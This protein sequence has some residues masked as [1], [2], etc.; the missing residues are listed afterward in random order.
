MLETVER[1]FKELAPAVDF[2][3]LRFVSEQ[4]EAIEVRQDVLQP[5]DTDDDVGVMITVV[6]GGGLGYSATS[7]L[8]LSGLHAALERATDWARKTAGHA[9]VDHGRIARPAPVGDYSASVA[10]PWEDTPLG[11]R[12]DRV[13]T[14]CQRLKTDDRIVDWSASLWWLASEQLYLTSDGGRTH[15]KFEYLIPGLS[16]TANEGSETVNRRYG[17][18]DFGRQGGLEILD[19]VDFDHQAPR[20]ADEVIQL[21]LAPNCPTG[22]MDLL[23]APDQMYLQIHESI[24]H[25][26]ELDRILGDERNYAGTSF[27]TLDMLGS[28]RYGSDLLNITFDPT[29]ADEFATYQWDDDG[30]AAD[31]QYIIRD[32]ILERALGGIT[33]QLRADQPGVANSRA[34]SWNR[35]P[36]DR[37]AN[38]NLEPG[39]ST[40]DELIGGVEN[41]IY[42]QRNTSWSIDDSRNKFQFGC[43]MGHLIRD[44]ELA[45]MV[46]KPNYKGISA[47]FWRALKGVGDADHFEVLGT[48]F[49]GK[50]E[51]NQVIR[52]GHASPPALFGDVEVFGGE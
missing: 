32:G 14:E 1:H 4:N 30:V 12:I 27:V 33:S 11:D 44:G 41:G 7:D 52:V 19:A 25:P 39:T 8:S 23:L 37:M 49:C 5:V 48:P 45:G 13:R 20:L 47:T 42:M 17:G 9:V 46:K 6:D 26:L 36:I 51:P 28:Y 34:C 21:L 40:L 18:F 31:K 22:T 16:V 38:L 10:Q 50:G 24:G 2:C 35:P 15:Q 43:E 3:S 29:I